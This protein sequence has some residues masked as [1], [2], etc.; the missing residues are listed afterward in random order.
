MS[1]K[2]G[3]YMAFLALFCASTAASQRLSDFEAPQPLPPGSALVVGFLGGWERWNDD[4]RSV[5][6]VALQLRRH[7]FSD[8]YVVTAGNHKRRTALKFIRRALDLNKNGRIDPQ[9]TEN[10]RLVL[11]GQSWGGGAV[12]KT[13]RDLNRLGVPVLLTIQVDSVGVTDGL[14][15]PNVK[16]AANFYQKD[17]LTIRGES[18]IRAED[19]SKTAI[20]GNF[21]MS[22]YFHPM[23]PSTSWI[24]RTF[25]GSH[26]KMESDPLLWMQVEQLILNALR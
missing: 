4:E 12:V 20:L 13:A 15:P 1:A 6:Q 2:T 8:V 10:A 22:Y 5:R 9:E 19:P 16:M 14:I 7:S 17:L 25:G 24:R 11:Y 21:R 26:A 23:D 3:Y 18:E